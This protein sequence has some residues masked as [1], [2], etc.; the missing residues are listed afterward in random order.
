MVYSANCGDVCVGA[1][2]MGLVESYSFNSGSDGP[3]LIVLGAIHGDEPCGPA[4]IA[5]IME[6]LDAGEITLL[7]GSVCFVPIS[8]PEA[9]KQ[10]K[11]EVGENLNRILRKTD[12]PT[13]YEAKLANE[14]CALID[15]SD[16]MLDLHSS[17]APGPVNLFLDY[18]TDENV[19]LAMS[20]GPEYSIYD[21]PKVYEQNPH[22]FQSHT[23]DHY[24]HT[25]GKSGILIECGQHDNSESVI[26]AEQSILRVFVHLGMIAAPAGLELMH[27]AG[28]AVHMRS[29]LAREREGDRLLKDWRHL[30]LVPAGTPIAQRESGE[31]VVFD[32]DIVIIFPK[33][34][35]K[36]GGEWFYVGVLGA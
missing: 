22:A 27:D 3:R 33:P 17:Y 21:W 14:L 16:V 5:R 23:S 36:V 7:Q 34:Y 15:E 29:I 12:N 19:A 30:E 35:A 9:Y 6:K 25:A 20:L 8:N 18:P 11:R 13:L 24:A 4:G 31:S 26:V 2:G 10:G 28:T 1:V 32:T